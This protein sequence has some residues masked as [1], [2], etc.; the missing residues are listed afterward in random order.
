MRT[1]VAKAAALAGLLLLG[2]RSVPETP[3]GEVWAVVNGKPIVRAD[4]ERQFRRELAGLPTP[5]TEEEALSHKLRLLGELIQ[6][7]IL[8]QKAAQRGTL[9]SD[10]EVEA[11]LE[12]LHASYTDP[13]FQQ[14]LEIL[15]LTRA[16]LRDE[17]RRELS[18]RKL[19]EQELAARV[20]VSDT[21]VTAY[22]EAHREEFRHPEALYHVA[23]ILVTPRAESEVRNLASDDARSEAQARRKIEQL[24]T[25]LRAGEDFAEL[26]RNFSEDPNT[27]LAGGD[28]GFFLESALEQSDPALRRVVR[29]LAVG[30]TS[31]VVRNRTGYHL[32][33]LLERQPAGQRELSEPE[34]QES[35]RSYLRAKKRALLEAA[36]LE[37][38]RNQ[39]RVVNYLAR[40]ILESGRA[41]P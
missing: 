5:P 13:E 4:V 24:L 23:H 22:Y 10:S 1:N 18:I 30:S 19:L 34:V 16:E 14:Q 38:A 12:Q 3:E 7:E 11:R 37:A 20:E 6:Q 32:V 21:E 29:G 28:L 25:R 2:C 39:A 27:A 33:K 35:V 26:A 9:A 41:L 8:L 15:G 31:G 17:L 40:Q 36:Y